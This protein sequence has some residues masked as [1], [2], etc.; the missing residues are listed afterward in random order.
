MRHPS[1]GYAVSPSFFIRRVLLWPSLSTTVVL[2][3][4]AFHGSCMDLAVYDSF[5][6]V[7]P[8]YVSVPRSFTIIHVSSYFLVNDPTCRR[9]LLVD[10]PYLTIVPNHRVHRS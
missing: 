7:T 9:L 5:H 6:F 10:Q 8:L 1:S 4:P 2:V 3:F